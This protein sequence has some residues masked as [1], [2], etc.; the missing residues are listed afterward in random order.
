MVDG[1]WIDMNEIANPFMDS[2]DQFAMIDDNQAK[3]VLPTERC[4]I[5]TA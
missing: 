3:D 1:M 5:A 2:T 4:P